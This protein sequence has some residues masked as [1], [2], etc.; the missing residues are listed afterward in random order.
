MALRT[1]VRDFL[2]LF[3]GAVEYGHFS[4]KDRH[5]NIQALIDLN[6]TPSQQREILLGLTPEDYMDGP[7]PEDQDSTKEVWEFGKKI[8]EHE[9]Y[10]K[11]RVTPVKGKRNVYFALVWSFHPAEFPIRNPLRGDGP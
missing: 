3:K 7:K 10:I 2:N 6:M 9:I 1:D 8:D 5:K 4:V 11:L